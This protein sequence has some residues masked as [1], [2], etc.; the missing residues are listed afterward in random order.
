MKGTGFNVEASI[1]FWWTK[2]KLERVT[3]DRQVHF[4]PALVF[5]LT[6]HS[7]GT[8]EADADVYDNTSIAAGR[9]FDLYCVDE[10]MAQLVFPVPVVFVKGIY[11]D[12]GTNCESVTVHYLP[13]Q[14]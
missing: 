3:G 8:A 6:I 11:V 10:A 2:T 4:G 1:P 9:K 7:D 5:S 14:P 12:I 13:F